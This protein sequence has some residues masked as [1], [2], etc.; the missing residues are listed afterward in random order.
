MTKLIAALIL[1]LSAT[2]AVADVTVK[3]ENSRMTTT[4]HSGDLVYDLN[5]NNAVQ[6]DAW[7][8]STVDGEIT[9]ERVAVTGC[10][11]GNGRIASLD[12]T[13]FKVVGEQHKWLATGGT[14]LDSIAWTVC[15][16]ANT[17]AGIDNK[18]AKKAKLNKSAI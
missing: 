16:M 4:V 3:S 11:K 5:E 17:Q 14:L 12:S 10:T 6:V 7:I 13:T 18:A 8:T 1:S 9:R 2:V 15:T